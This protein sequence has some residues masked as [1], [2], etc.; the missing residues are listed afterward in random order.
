MA[1]GGK[2]GK[3]AVNDT[4]AG[5]SATTVQEST[6]A[7]RPELT[8]FSNKFLA[9]KFYQD[10]MALVTELNKPG[11]QNTLL[12]L[13]KENARNMG[14]AQ[15]PDSNGLTL[16]SRPLNN[17]GGAVIIS[18]PTPEGN[19]EAYFAALVLAIHKADKGGMEGEANYYVLEKSAANNA[20]LYL[21]DEGQ[22]KLKGGDIRPDIGGLWD[23][24]R[25]QV[26]Q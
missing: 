13:W 17:G 9:Q 24:I 14:L 11:G 1:C 21:L 6:P 10:P 19:G 20:R 15:A 26:R 7:A 4:P 25:H 23:A 12:A 16:E 22:R 5:N 2:S 8:Q 18:L 3:K